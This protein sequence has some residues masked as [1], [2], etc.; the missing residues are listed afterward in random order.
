MQEGIFEQAVEEEWIKA[1]WYVFSHGSS[2]YDF[3]TRWQ[4]QASH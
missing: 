1:E 3:T 4:V 2:Q